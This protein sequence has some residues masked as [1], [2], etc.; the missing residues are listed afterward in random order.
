[1][2]EYAT[3]TLRAPVAATAQRGVR[4]R[5]RPCSTAFA[6]AAA[7]CV[8]APSGYHEM[9]ETLRLMALGSRNTVSVRAYGCSLLWSACAPA[10]YSS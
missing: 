2:M 9:Y 4:T 7:A 1:M 10:K 6:A 5:V 3:A 8:A